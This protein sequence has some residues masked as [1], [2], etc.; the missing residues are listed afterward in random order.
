[1]SCVVRLALVAAS[2]FFVLVGTAAATRIVGVGGNKNGEDV[3]I[4]VGDVIV[5]SLRSSAPSSGYAWRVATINR[6][7]LRPDSVTYVQGARPSTVVGY[8]G[9]QVLLFKAIRQGKSPLKLNYRKAGSAVNSTFEV[10]VT[11]APAGA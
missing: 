8:G 7:V 2:I 5:V 6:Q 3:R 11:V 10:D 4:D 1:V 9:V